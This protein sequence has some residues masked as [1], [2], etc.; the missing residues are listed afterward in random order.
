MYVSSNL[1]SGET[2]HRAYTRKKEKENL[3]LEIPESKQIWD[4]IQ[5]KEDM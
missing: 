2:C 5:I 1:L 4:C 3:E